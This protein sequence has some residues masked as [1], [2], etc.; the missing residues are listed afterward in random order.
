MKLNETSNTINY[1]NDK[2]MLAVAPNKESR[3]E[4]SKIVRE[5]V[6]KQRDKAKETKSEHH[7]YTPDIDQVADLMETAQK[8]IE[9]V[10]F[11][12]LWRLKTPA[13][14]RFA[15]AGQVYLTFKAKGVCLAYMK[16]VIDTPN[17]I[18][19]KD[20]TDESIKKLIYDRDQDKLRYLTRK[21]DKTIL[22]LIYE[23]K[24]DRFLVISFDDWRAD[25]A[26]DTNLI[27]HDAKKNLQCSCAEPECIHLK[28]HS[29]WSE[30]G[31][32]M[33]MSDQVIC[34]RLHK[35]EPAVGTGSPVTLEDLSKYVKAE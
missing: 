29:I 31:T 1:R 3:R 34:D 7:S 9:T 24:D 22:Y 28:I 21:D 30:G 32:P 10:D 27:Y 2:S 14:F 25:K 17:K 26:L 13:M 35:T 20:F 8:K 6:Q 5:D 18:I 33:V 19:L 23:T 4:I 15:L 12:Q 16:E 11:Y